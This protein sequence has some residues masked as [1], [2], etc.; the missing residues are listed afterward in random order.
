MSDV[1]KLSD[2]DLDR[3]IARYRELLAALDWEEDSRETANFRRYLVAKIRLLEGERERRLEA[4]STDRG[5]ASSIER[6]NNE[7]SNCDD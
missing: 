4:R 5:R 2:A 7:R 1:T 3:L 6:S